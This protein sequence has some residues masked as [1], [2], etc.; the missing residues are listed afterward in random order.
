MRGAGKA[1][2]PTATAI[3]RVLA[4]LLAQLTKK[5]AATHKQD[6]ASDQE[7]FGAFYAPAP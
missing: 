7:L 5:V 4:P 2:T 6:K 1:T 3:N